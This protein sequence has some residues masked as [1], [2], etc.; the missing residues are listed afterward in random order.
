[1]KRLFKEF[2]HTFGF[3]VSHT[4]RK[5]RDGEVNGVH[6]HFVTQDIIH[7]AI[8]NGEFIETAVFSGNTYGTSK[9]SVEDVQHHGKVCVLDI[10]IEGVKQVKKSHLDAVYVF[11]NPPSIEELEMRLRKRNTETEE[12]LQKR[13]KTAKSELEYGLREGN[14][15]IV[16]HNHNLSKAY[17]EFRDFILKQL[18]AQLAGGI[19]VNIDRVRLDE[20]ESF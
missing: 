5:P 14:F 2:P 15:D 6:Y 10:E 20:N 3:S 18:E 8:K 17:Q 4:T 12:S 19:N 13:L 1:L 9:K 7:E 11:I 16:I